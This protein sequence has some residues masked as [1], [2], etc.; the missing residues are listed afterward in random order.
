MFL[1]SLTLWPN[2]W[3]FVV[4]SPGHQ[5]GNGSKFLVLLDSLAES[6]SFRSFAKLR[7]SS[8]VFPISGI[9]RDVQLHV[10]EMLTQLQI[11]YFGRVKFRGSGNETESRFR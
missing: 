5:T 6:Q 10:R 2:L 4:C 11:Y 3:F 8:D 9:K 1:N 7:R